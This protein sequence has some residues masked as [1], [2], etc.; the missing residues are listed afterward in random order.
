MYAYGLPVAINNL[1]RTDIRKND[2]KDLKKLG[3]KSLAIA[4]I[5][6]ENN[7]LAFLVAHQCSQVKLWSSDVLR[8]L[9]ERANGISFALSQMI[10]A[11]KS[12]DLDLT[13]Q[14]IKNSQQL[15]MERPTNNN[16]NGDWQFN[17]QK[18]ILQDDKT[19]SFLDVK[20]KISDE[21]E[22][23]NILR[24]PTSPASK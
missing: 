1:D 5:S 21:I 11:Q 17:S 20:D 9:A 12:P 13:P 3:V 2:L 23:E 10:I 14:I 7:L 4:P 6:V 22:A 19:Q 8:F 15:T 16:G 24:A 18:S